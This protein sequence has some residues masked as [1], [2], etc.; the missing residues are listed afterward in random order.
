MVG[1][2]IAYFALFLISACP[3]LLAQNG[4]TESEIEIG[5]NTGYVD[6]IGESLDYNLNVIERVHSFET[7]SGN[8]HVVYNWFYDGTAIGSISGNAWS[9]H[10][11]WPYRLN[12]G[13]SRLT[14]GEKVLVMYA[15]LDGQ[16]RLKVDL[17]AQRTIDANGVVRVEMESYSFRC[18]GR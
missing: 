3:A 8:Y 12:A 16:S 10:G 15:P 18:V 9:T 17:L 4:V 5:G 11:V 7:S 1:K 2:R 13:G 6:C 14:R